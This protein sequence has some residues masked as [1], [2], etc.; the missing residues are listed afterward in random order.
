MQCADSKTDRYVLPELDNAAPMKQKKKKGF[1]LGICA[2]LAH[3]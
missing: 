2:S 1:G 3:C